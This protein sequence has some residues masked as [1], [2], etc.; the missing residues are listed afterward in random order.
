MGFSLYFLNKNR[1]TINTIIA[2]IFTLMSLTLNGE[3]PR[4]AIKIIVDAADA[5]SP[6]E[7]GWRNL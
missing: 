4:N 3:V 2:I 5:I 6:A 1:E 7:L